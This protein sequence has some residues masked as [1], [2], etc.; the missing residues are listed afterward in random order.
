MSFGKLGAMGRGMGHL[1]ALGTVNTLFDFNFSNGTY[2][3]ASASSFTTTRTGTMWAP[4]STG[5]WSSFG[6]GQVAITSGVGL[7]RRPASTN[8]IR[9][10]TAQGL[11]AGSPGTLPD[12]WAV[13]TPTGLT[14]TISTATYKGLQYVGLR[15]QGTTTSTGSFIVAPEPASGGGAA[16]SGQKWS[17]SWLIIY[18]APHAALNN[19]AIEVQGTNGSTQTEL[20]TSANFISSLSATDWYRPTQT[21]TLANAGTTRARTRFQTNTVNSGTAIDFTIWFACPQ[22]EQMPAATPPMFSNGSAL[23]CDADSISLT[24]AGLDS[25]VTL[26][27]TATSTSPTSNA[28]NQILASLDDGGSN[29]VSVGRLATTAYPGTVVSAGPA[30]SLSS[31]WAINASGTIKFSF[32]SAN[33]AI[34]FGGTTSGIVT[35]TGRPTGLTT[36]HIGA[37]K[38]GSSSWYGPIARI[39]ATRSREVTGL[40]YIVS[41]GDSTAAGNGSSNAAT[42]SWFALLASDQGCLYSNQ[43]NPG[44]DATDCATRFLANWTSWPGYGDPRTLYVIMTGYNQHNDTTG[45]PAAIKSITDALDAVSARYLVCNITNGENN[46]PAEYSG[47]ADY[48][49]IISINSA[50]LTR[51]GARTVQQREALVASYNS[52]I[53][54]DVTDFGH[55]IVP[56]SKRS[57]NI[58]CNDAGQLVQKTTIKTAMQANGWA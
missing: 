58:H 34:S 39:Y 28:S 40:L 56:S 12:N 5:T 18:A 29:Y 44:E 4:D 3:G 16:S 13:A 11:V 7:A 52:G 31:A 48:A 23:S 26:A 51:Y 27:A 21:F 53:P 38:D 55:D 54:Q 50:E 35:T 19:F 2:R 33:G 24:L 6:S 57:D 32:Q 41:V 45:T 22:I 47:G 42:T 15:W 25:A 37:D 10:C 17:S 49:N 46:A 8:S 36:L 30:P 20:S 43:G 1:G 14:R 9:N